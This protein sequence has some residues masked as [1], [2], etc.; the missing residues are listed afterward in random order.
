[1]STDLTLKNEQL[2]SYLATNDSIRALEKTVDNGQSRLALQVVLEI[3]SELTERLFALEEKINPVE[4]EPEEI[5]AASEVVIESQA[6]AK[7]ESSVKAE[8]DQS[9][10]DEAV[11]TKSEEIKASK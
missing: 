8:K 4:D 1:M 2:I 11:A 10:P 3:V 5:L 6:P 9:K 7:L